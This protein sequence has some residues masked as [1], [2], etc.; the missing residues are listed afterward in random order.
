MG[1]AVSTPDRRRPRSSSQGGFVLSKIHHLSRRVLARL[2]REHGLE[3]PNPGQGR[4]LFALWQGDGITMTALAE[5]TAL[6][7]ST[8]TRMLE[9]MEADGMVR[10]EAAPADRRSVKVVL[11]PRAQ[12]MLSAFAVVSEEM[13]RI[14]YRGLSADEIR[15]FDET[16]E[17]IYGNLASEE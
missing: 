17:R 3:Q 10:R 11:Q 14:F 8:L 7:K 15:V 2:M 13:A 12:R 4:I 5:R 1:R 16:L 6:E 9:R